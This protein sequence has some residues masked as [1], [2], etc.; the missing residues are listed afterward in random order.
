M[1][2]TPSPPGREQEGLL[3]LTL[4]GSQDSKLSEQ[5]PPATGPHGD[6]GRE[7]WWKL[8]MARGYSKAGLFPGDLSWLSLHPLD[9]KMKGWAMVSPFLAPEDRVQESQQMPDH[10]GY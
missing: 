7:S 1:E 5:W 9:S 3:S 10:R 4:G 8:V 2:A 6:R